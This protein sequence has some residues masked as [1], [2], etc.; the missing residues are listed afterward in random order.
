MQAI[1]SPLYQSFL[2]SN[3]S[4]IIAGI[5]YMFLKIHQ[6]KIYE[7]L[8][9]SNLKSAKLFSD[10]SKLRLSRNPEDFCSFLCGNAGIFAVSAIINKNLNNIPG[11]KEDINNFLKGFPVCQRVHF[12]QN[13]NDE[14]L[15]GR[16]GYLSGI[17]WMNQFLESNQRIDQNI[18]EQIS[19]VMI[20]SGTEYAQRT[21]C[22]IPLMY[23][24]YGD[25]YL[26]AAHGISS[27]LHML[28][29]SPMFINFD[30]V[31]DAKR[32]L[33]KNAIDMFLQ[34]QDR[35]GNF[36]SVLEEVNMP[37]H[38][39]VHWCHGAPGVIYLFAKAYLIFRESKYL[40]VCLKCGDLVWNK[41]LLMKGP[42]IC[43]GIAGNGYVFLLLFR[44][45]QDP[46][47]LYRAS[48]FAEF[49]TNDTFLKA[50]R[51]P[52]C[53]FSLYEGLA[54]TVCFL[55]DL[56]QP[57]KSSFPFMDVFDSKI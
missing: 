14:I 47:H 44:L 22:Q 20:E 56:L 32:M 9:Q 21:K 54:G 34:T 57:H 19:N 2:V 43:H 55:V 52:D 16:A 49:L 3:V 42:G 53:P 18:V 27:I 24:C 46:K 51:T 48:K 35:Y 31:L 37:E 12:N 30:D 6:S 17:F 25:K 50:A 36:P 8:D 26:G 40:D 5:A 4:F 28:L 38:K 33:V 39:L 45:T 41:G 23:E 10:R 13:G 15:F 11:F 29:E 1:I 7:D